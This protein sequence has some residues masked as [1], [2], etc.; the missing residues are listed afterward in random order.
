MNADADK[1][2]LPSIQVESLAARCVRV[3][4][5]VRKIWTGRRALTRLSDFSDHEL[6]DIGLTR[7]DLRRVYAGPF[8]ADPTEP[9]HG[10]ARARTRGR[11]KP[12]RGA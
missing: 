10:L 8:F 7:E 4:A 1:A 3:L 11:I 5:R 9:L 2:A 6:Q 12:R